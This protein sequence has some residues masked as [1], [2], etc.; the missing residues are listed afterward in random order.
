MLVHFYY[1]ISAI[2]RIGS[3][4]ST[5]TNTP[6]RDVSVTD[7]NAAVTPHFQLVEPNSTWNAV[8]WETLAKECHYSVS[9]TAERMNMSVRTFELH[10]LIQVRST[11]RQF[12]AALRLKEVQRM[13]RLGLPI[14]VVSHA[15]GYGHVSNFSRWLRHW[16]GTTFRQ[17]Q[18]RD[19]AAQNDN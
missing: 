9:A 6:S 4:N 18:V 13:A 5:M 11:P 17:L 12:L 2:R 7:H 15:V 16:T 19:I 8:N 10:C 14:K 1:F 3:G